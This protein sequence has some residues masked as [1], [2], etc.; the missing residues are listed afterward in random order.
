MTPSRVR[1]VA[2]AGLR[3]LQA[4]AGGEH[5]GAEAFAARLQI[6][7]GQLEQQQAQQ[8]N[9]LIGQLGTAPGNVPGTSEIA[10]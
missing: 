3:V 4:V 5:G 1:A 10:A 9:A 7:A 2:E 8:R 6:Y